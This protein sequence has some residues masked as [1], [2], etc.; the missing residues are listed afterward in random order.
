DT[1]GVEVV[2]SDDTSYAL[3]ME[4]QDFAIVKLSAAVEM[5]NEDV[6]ALRQG[7][8]HRIMLCADFD[9]VDAAYQT[10]V[11][12]GV[13]FIHPPT[14]QPWGWRAAYFADPAGNIWEFRQSIPT[15]R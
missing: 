10:L 11:A 8:G 13:Q 14:D 7:I 3:R 9:D 4:G 1:L 2:F 12:R 6:L 5:L 15:K